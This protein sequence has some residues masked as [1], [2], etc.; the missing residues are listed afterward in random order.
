MIW[1]LFTV[2]GKLTHNMK[3]TLFVQFPKPDHNRT[4]DTQWF[5]CLFTTF[6]NIA[7]GRIQFSGCIR[8]WHSVQRKKNQTKSKKTKKQCLTCQT[9]NMGEN[10]GNVTDSSHLQFP[11]RDTQ[12]LTITILH[13]KKVSAAGS[14]GEGERALPRHHKSARLCI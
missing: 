8:P 6:T 14:G 5:A 2:W 4:T 1:S 3:A 12:H 7:G 10:K 9:N 11:N 13:T